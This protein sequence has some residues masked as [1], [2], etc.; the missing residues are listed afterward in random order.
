METKATCSEC[1]NE[2]EFYSARIVDVKKYKVYCGHC[3]ELAR[4][5]VIKGLADAW[6]KTYPKK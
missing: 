5:R 4:Q 3:K 2:F 6:N 1:G